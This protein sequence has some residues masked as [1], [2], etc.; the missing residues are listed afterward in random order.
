MISKEIKLVLKKY[1]QRKAQ[2]Q[3]ISLVKEPK[4]YKIRKI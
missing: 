3:M 2:V 4:R 1:P